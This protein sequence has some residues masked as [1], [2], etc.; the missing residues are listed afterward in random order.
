[1]G[2]AR[3]CARRTRTGRERRCRTGAKEPVLYVLHG[4]VCGH[5]VGPGRRRRAVVVER[6]PNPTFLG[7]VGAAPSSVRAVT[8]ARG[9][10]NAILQAVRPLLP[11]EVSATAVPADGVHRTRQAVRRRQNA[12]GVETIPARDKKV[13][14]NKTPIPP[15]P[16]GG[17]PM[18][19]T[20]NI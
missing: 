19:G 11:H 5:V 15:Q 14:K 9:E 8:P 12:P 16:L 1:M 3:S 10:R 18:G 6:A 7:A 13:D 2:N 4:I 17:L 20:K